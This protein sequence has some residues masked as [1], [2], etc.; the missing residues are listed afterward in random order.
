MIPALT[1]IVAVY[2]TVRLA[3]IIRDEY[4][5]IAGD[6]Y[7][8]TTAVQVMAMLAS[9]VVFVAA[10]YVLWQGHVAGR[11]MEEA[12]ILLESYGP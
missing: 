1:L 2:V 4:E 6:K 8:S 3:V 11:E 12:R 5:R 9:V 10:V 7:S